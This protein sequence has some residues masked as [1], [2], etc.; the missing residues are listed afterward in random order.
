MPRYKRNNGLVRKLFYDE[1]GDPYFKYV[2]DPDAFPYNLR[3]MEGVGDLTADITNLERKDFDQLRQISPEF[4]QYVISMA[5]ANDPAAYGTQ[6]RFNTGGRVSFKFGKR[7]IDEGKRAFLKLLAALGIGTAGAKSG[8]SLFSKAV[9]KKAVSTAGADIVATTPGMPDWFPALV[10]KIIKEG[11]DVTKK[12]ATKER[13][14]VHTKKLDKDVYGD[15]VTVYR[16]LDTGDIRVEVDSVSNMGEAPIQLDYKAP[17]VIDEGKS[18]GKKTKSEF[19]ASE[20][21]PSYEMIGPDDAEV[22]WDNENIVGNVD[23][24]FSDTT[25]L[26]NYAEGKKPTIKEIVTRKRKTDKV[27]KLNEDKSAQ[28]DYSVNKFGEGP[29]EAYDDYLPD[30]DDID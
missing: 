30:I 5:L 10:N 2:K 23:A 9:G 18:V 19:S 20:S 7:G 11:D 27:K 21:E 6:E 4:N 16:D 13:E 28:V 15:E 22:N 29:D 24:L 17:S 8:V 25:K 3:T 1:K 26:K 14:I 12:L